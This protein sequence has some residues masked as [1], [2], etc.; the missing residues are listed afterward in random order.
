MTILNS[1]PAL[2][3]GHLRKLMI[4]VDIKIKAMTKSA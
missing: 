2:V 1:L 3:A 4:P